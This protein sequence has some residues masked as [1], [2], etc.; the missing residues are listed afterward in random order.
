MHFHVSWV[1][2]QGWNYGPQGSWMLNRIENGQSVLQVAFHPTLPREHR[3]VLVD[4]PSHQH[5]VLSAFGT[6]ATPVGAEQSHKAQLGVIQE[7]ERDWGEG[8]PG[9]GARWV[10]EAG[11]GG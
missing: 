9:S 2:T 3:Q 5:L 8:I 7:L 11:S 6:L 1:K 4:P 10:Q